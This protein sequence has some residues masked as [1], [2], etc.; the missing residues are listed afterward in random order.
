MVVAFAP[1]KEKLITGDELLAMG[2]IGPCELIDGRIIHMTPTGEEHGMIESNLVHDLRAFVRQH[3]LGRV[4]SGEVGIYIRR[5]PDRIRAADVAFVSAERLARP[6]KGFLE[7][8]PDLMVE[9]MSPDDRWPAMRE[10]LADYFSIGVERVWVVEPQNR[11]VLVCS[12]STDVTELDEDDTLRGEGALKGF[13]MRVG[14]LFV[15]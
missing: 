12:S 7:V 13:A 15:E 14:D 11:Q 6:A 9:I 1:P 3:K 10:K 8:A 5:R 4:S 2:D